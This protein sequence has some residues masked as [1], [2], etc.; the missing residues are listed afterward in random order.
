MSE[1][2]PAREGAGLD[3]LITHLEKQPDKGEP[4]VDILRDYRKCL[5]RIA[6]TLTE[7]DA[8]RTAMVELLRHTHASCRGPDNSEEHWPDCIVARYRP[9]VG[10]KVKVRGHDD[11]LKVLE[12]VK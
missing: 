6:L 1:R 9:M 10:L 4:L 7:N 2:N 8:L 5:A 11:V 12:P 3:S